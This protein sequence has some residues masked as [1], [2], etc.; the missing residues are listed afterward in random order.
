[1][2]VSRN[3]QSRHHNIFRL[4]VIN[5]LIASERALPGTTLLDG[6]IT[7]NE[8]SSAVTKLKN[9]KAAGHDGVVA[10]YLKFADMMMIRSLH[11]L[12]ELVWVSEQIPDDWRL[13]VVRPIP[14]LGRPVALENLRP[15]TPLH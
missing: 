8:V 6:A 12:I 2:T 11:Q 15:I 3:L 14:K 4:S 13:G 10:E 9:Y 7:W 1:M 5:A